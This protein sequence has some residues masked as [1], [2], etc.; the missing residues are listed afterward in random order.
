LVCPSDFW[1]PLHQGHRLFNPVES[2]P[3]M[4]LISSFLFFFA[5]LAGKDAD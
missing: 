1:L 3:V 2:Q 5:T 4:G